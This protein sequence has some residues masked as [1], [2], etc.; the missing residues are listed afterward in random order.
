MA[1]SPLLYDMCKLFPLSVCPWASIGRMMMMVT[2]IW[3]ETLNV[4]YKVP[5]IYF[6]NNAP[7][8]DRHI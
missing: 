5:G 4:T 2:G 8:D 6:C 1:K 7:F 3:R